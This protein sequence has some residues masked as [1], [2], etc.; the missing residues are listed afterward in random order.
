MK[1]IVILIFLVILILTIPKVDAMEV[2]RVKNDYY[3]T[4]YHPNGVKYSDQDYSYYID[5]KIV[6]CIEP[7][8]KLGSDYSELDNYD[9][10]YENK[11]RIILAAHF[12]YMYENRKAYKYAMAT[13]SII[14]K[15]ILGT[16]PVYSTKLWEK[17]EILDLSY[18]I[19][20]IENSIN[21]F[22]KKLNL[23]TKD[24]IIVGKTL[25]FE[26]INDTI[27]NY[28]ISDYNDSDP[29]LGNLVHVRYDTAG[30]QTLSIKSKRYYKSNYKVYGDANHQHLL[31]PGDIPELDYEKTI[32]VNPITVKFKI[33]DSETKEEVNNV[34]LEVDGKTIKNNEKYIINYYH[35]LDISIKEVPEG[36]ILD[37]SIK[38]SENYSQKEY[39][40]KLSIDPIYNDYKVHKTY[41]EVNPEENAIFELINNDTEKLHG[42]YFT[43]KDGDF[44][45]HL[46]YGNYT[47]NQ[48]KGIEGYNLVSYII[49]NTQPK[50]RTVKTINLNDEKILDN[51]KEKLIEEKPEQNEVN[52]TDEQEPLELVQTG[53]DYSQLSFILYFLLICLLR[54]KIIAI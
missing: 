37:E 41:D 2:T 22:E 42:V 8:V 32:I 35:V 44:D 21:R 17:G 25:T 39:T 33:I 6:Y 31:M 49:Y 12:G 34:T 3:Y 4:R 40:I 36:Y 10:P 1:K 54:K 9:I 5:G 20:N 28:D 52:I 46:R 14:W 29:L 19:K 50:T 53:K 47:L 26:D 24:D 45:L 43:N 13:Q 7:G 23:V 30:P 48:L 38:N 15:E 16:Y 27:S 18:Y 51:N 11:L